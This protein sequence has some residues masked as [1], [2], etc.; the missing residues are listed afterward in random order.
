MGLAGMD[1]G[2]VIVTAGAVLGTWFLARRDKQTDQTFS[3]AVA[4]GALQSKV[5]AL[6]ATQDQHANALRSLASL[7][8]EV[9]HMRE[10]LD[11]V[12]TQFSDLVT[13]TIANAGAAIANVGAHAG[14]GI[15]PDV[16]LAM[17]E[18]TVPVA[19]ATPAKRRASKRATDATRAPRAK[20]PAKPSAA[21]SR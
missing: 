6:A 2:N 5:E 12:L 3:A 10:S 11:R 16:A 1:W 4:I 21:R 14:A 17:P 7:P 9:S 18:G 13:A 19:V 15:D 8:A 20:S